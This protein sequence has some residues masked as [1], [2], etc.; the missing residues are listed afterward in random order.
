MTGVLII[1]GVFI[2]IGLEYLYARR[3]GRTELFRYENSVANL[4]VGIC[5]RLIYLMM[6]PV[7]HGLFSY[8]YEN[9]AITQIS[10]SWFIWIGLLLL[11]DF[12]W[13]WYHRLG[14][15]V[16]LFWAAHVVHHQSPDF[17]LTVAA[18]ITVFQ[19]YIR[20]LFWCLLPL[21][22]FSPDMVVQILL[23]H[24]AYSF[25]T[26]TQVVGK[27]GILEY[28]FI[29]P[30]HHRVHHACN[31]NYLDKNF[32]DVF[33]FW[34][35]LFGTFR[36][37]SDSEKPVYGLTHELRSY[38]FAWQHFHYYAE[39]FILMKHRTGIKNKLGVW[40]APPEI[41][42]PGIRA[43]LERKLLRRRKKMIRRIL[44]GYINLQLAIALALL[45]LIT[46]G[47]GQLPAHV[48]IFSSLVII[49]T[50]I[51]CGAVLERKRWVIELEFARVVLLLGWGCIASGH[52]YWFFLFS[53][54]TLLGLFLLPVRA[55]YM[56]TVF[57]RNTVS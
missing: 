5:E 12:I 38:S 36:V 35:K 34:D 27:L 56:N 20:T 33:V 43:A 11:T 4:S 44:K 42:P 25:F 26:H 40:F 8:I 31:E 2:F 9:Y 39:L 7:F 22:G 51:I 30:S 55:W 13:Y 1:T 29:T 3:T 19:A 16:N 6:A 37:E 21:A 47:F 46:A 41:M 14:H 50:L 18:R 57:P 49:F 24:G 23:V 10:S 54:L 53:F 17:N 52:P 48:L 45:L 15:R 28:V 32:G